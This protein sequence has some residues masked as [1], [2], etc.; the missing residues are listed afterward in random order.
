FVDLAAQDAPV[1]DRLKSAVDAVVTKGNY[2]LGDEVRE[3][4]EAFAS[5]CGVREAVGVSSGL[6]AL[7][8]ILRGYDVGPGDEVIVPAL[9]FVGTASAVALVGA[10][11]VLVDV[12]DDFNLSPAAAAK[13]ITPRTKAI[14]AVHLYGRLAQVDELAELA[15]RHG[16][17]FIEDSAQAHGA[18]LAGRRAGSFGDAAA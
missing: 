5:Y 11:P 1:R 16:L 14:M 15:K 4:E 17:K 12:E 3:F 7:E 13:A 18:S 9:T 6:A 8:L 2:I 10:T